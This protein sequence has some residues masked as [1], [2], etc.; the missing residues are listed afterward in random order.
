MILTAVNDYDKGTD[1]AASLPHLQRAADRGDLDAII[2]VNIT[3]P[4]IITTICINTTITTILHI[5]FPFTITITMTMPMIMIIIDMTIM[6]I[7]LGTW[8]MTCMRTRGGGE[9]FSC[10]R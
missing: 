2:H 3:F 6:T 7:R 8:L 9:I 5:I 4:I 10:S 1:N